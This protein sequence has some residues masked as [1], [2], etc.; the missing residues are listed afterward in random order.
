MAV[1]RYLKVDIPK[2]H[3]TIERQSDGKPALIKYVLEAPY[4]REKGY[5]EPKRTTIGH[6]CPDDKSKMYP[7]SQYVKIFPKEWETVSGKRTVPTI[8]RMGIFSICQAI[9][10]KTGIKDLLDTAFGAGVS[11]AVMDFAMYSILHRSNAADSFESQMHN[12][13]LYSSSE[14]HNDT[15]YSEMFDR[16][17]PKEQILLFKK[18]WI[19][20]CKEEDV[21]SVW[22]CIDGSNDD[23]RSE[24]VTIAEN[25]PA[26][27]GGTSTPIVSFTYAVTDTGLPVCFDTYHGGLVDCREMQKILDDITHCGITVKGVILDRGYCN[28]QVLEYLNGREIPYII[29]VKGEP[30]GLM[31]ITQKFGNTIKLN[32]E[33]LVPGAYLFGVQGKCQLF[34]DYKHEDYVT[35]FYDY[36]NGSDRITALL[37]NLYRAMDK[38]NADIRKGVRDPQIDKKYE[39]MIEIVTKTDESDRRRRVRYAAVNASGLQKALD[40]KGLYSVVS[41]K[42]MSAGQV[43][44]RY[45]SR[46]ESEIQFRF[47]KSQLGYGQTRVQ[48]DASVY[49]RFL[50]GF[51]AAIL[52]YEIW[53]AAKALDLKTSQMLIE[54]DR[55]EMERI[56]GVYTYTHTEKE[57][58][59]KL[60]GKLTPRTDVTALIDDSVKL[61]NDRIAGR[62]P[63]LRHRKTGPK[64]GSHHKQYDSDGNVVKKTGGVAKGTKRPDFNK[65][66]TPRKKPGTKPGTKLGKYNKDGSVRKKP[67]PKPGSHHAKADAQPE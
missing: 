16:R 57:A 21:E 6:Q 13:L 24:G 59:R 52:R 37:K 60:F 55:M 35:L 53:Q 39:S 17:L 64:S 1:Y 25:G 45:A 28:S 18:N 65:D 9:N 10:M 27:S 63:V 47:V 14:G 26:K 44:E 15:W 51:V 48:S 22:L 66:G 38:A 32:A 12:Q 43:H 46:D 23:C 7:T 49:A 41:S 54:I 67:G 58:V 20:Q 34:Q 40:E 8:K 33:Y 3:V 62:M 36:A 50:V 4:N 2:E 11:N 5:A 30:Q 42:Q 31:E 19:K 29:M 61:E 56:N